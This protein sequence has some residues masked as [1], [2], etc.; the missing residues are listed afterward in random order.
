MT[1]EKEI[2]AALEYIDPATLDYQSWM[3]I[4]MAIKAS[5]ASCDLW[6]EWSRRDPKR[7]DGGCYKKWDSYTFQNGN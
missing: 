4:G 2:K 3:Q 7:Y 5:G 1:N 6:D